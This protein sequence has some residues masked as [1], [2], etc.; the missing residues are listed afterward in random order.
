MPRFCVAG[1]V[2]GDIDGLYKYLLALQERTGV[3]LDAVIHVGDFGCYLPSGAAWNDVFMN[4]NFVQ[5]WLGQ[6]QIPIPTWVCPGNHE[7]YSVLKQWGAEPDRVHSLR[8]LPDGCV[9]EVMGVKIGAIWGNFSY[10]SWMNPEIIR[11]ARRNNPDSKKAMHIYKPSVELLKQA[12]EFDLFITHDA[13]AR[14]MKPMR[15]PP[16]YI[17]EALGLAHDEPASG[18]PGFNEIYETSKCKYH[19]FGHFHTFWLAQI[20]APKVT[21]LHCFAYNAEQSI[22]I[23]EF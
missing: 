4:T 23:V 18:C 10:R 3:K 2:H 1:D 13:P 5:Y 11:T 8:L 15:Q 20:Q 14:L 9:T 21:C 22:E 12:G 17:K 16:S 6:K 19:Y 7:D